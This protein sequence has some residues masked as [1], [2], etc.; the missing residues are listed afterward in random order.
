MTV[1]NLRQLDGGILDPDDRLCDV[2]DDRDQI[3]AVYTEHPA[4]SRRPS[5]SS[6][7]SFGTIPGDQ[8]G[9]TGRS[10][11]SSAAPS[12]S[13]TPDVFQVI[14]VEGVLG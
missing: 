11:A 12:R 7:A 13:H 1:A 10:L 9:G 14:K 8:Q 3:I 4:S 2:V 6:E 5:Q